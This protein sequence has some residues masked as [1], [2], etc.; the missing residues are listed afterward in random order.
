MIQESAHFKNQCFWFTS[1]I[2]KEAN[3]KPLTNRLKQVAVSE[4]EIIE[5][6]QGNKKSRFLAWTYL[7][8]KQQENWSKFRWK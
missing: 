5:M 3:L 6:A 4:Y 7:N 8:S 1:L 2:S